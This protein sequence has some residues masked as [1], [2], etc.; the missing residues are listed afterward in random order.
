[1]TRIILALL[2]LGC[3]KRDGQRDDVEGLF[4]RLRRSLPNVTVSM[5]SHSVLGERPYQEESISFMPPV[6][7]SRL[8]SV[9]EW[10]HAYA[11]NECWD[12]PCWQLML[13]KYDMKDELN[14]IVVD[15]PR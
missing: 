11:V 10:K 4:R 6:D 3:S 8:A 2:L 15:P 5:T 14:G 9:L 7:A 12:S 1:M 13:K